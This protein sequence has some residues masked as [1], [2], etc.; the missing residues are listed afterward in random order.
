V[1]RIKKLL[2]LTLIALAVAACRG[3]D[4]APS[5]TATFPPGPD[6]SGVSL[7][8]HQEPG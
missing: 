4:A 8:V 1:I 5:T 6:L 7:D 3:A 2:W